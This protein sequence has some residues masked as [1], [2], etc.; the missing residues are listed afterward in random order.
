[1]GGPLFIILTHS[2]ARVRVR[3]QVG[4]QM[5]IIKINY[6]NSNRLSA[7]ISAVTIPMVMMAVP[8]ETI[9]MHLS[10]PDGTYVEAYLMGDEH[11]HYVVSS[12]HN[13]LLE[14]NPEGF[15]ITAVR[16]GRE[17]Y[18]TAGDVAILQGD[19][20]ST[21]TLRHISAPKQMGRL[22]VE[23]RT[24]YPT[25]GEGEVHSLVVLIEYADTKFTIPDVQ[26]AISRLCNEEGYSDY[27]AK[28]SARDYYRV[29]SGGKFNPVFD[30]T[31]PITLSE[32]SKY[33]VGYGTGSICDRFGDAIRQ[34][35][36]ELHESG[37]VDFSKYDYDGDGVVDNV[38]FFFAGYG[39]A[40]TGRTDCIWP[41]QAD[42]QMFMD[43][44]DMPELV[45]DGKRIA[46]YACSAELKGSVPQINQ[47]YLCG[48]GTFCHE[49]GHVLG[50]PDLYDTV[51]GNTES[52]GYW[53]IMAYGSYN[54]K[55]TCPPMMSAYERWLCR[56]LELDEAEPGTTYCLSPATSDGYNGMRI[57]I[58]T[59]GKAREFYIIESRADESWDKPLADH[60]L[61]IWH[62][63]Y[64]E[65]AW[66]HNTVNCFGYPRVRLH[67]A[68]IE[69]D[70]TTWPGKNSEY[71]MTYPDLPNGLLPSGDVPDDFH[72]FLTDI[73]FDCKN[74]IG[75]VTYNKI[76][77]Y[78]TDVVTLNSNPEFEA[79]KR[80]V[81]LSWNP[82]SECEP[83]DEY[84]LTV[85][86][87]GTDGKEYV[88]DNMDEKNVNNVTE[89]TIGNIS[90]SAWKQEFNAYV[91]VV[92]Y[93]IPAKTI[94]NVIAF[95]PST[96]CSTQI[97]SINDD[98]YG[99]YVSGKCILA[100]EGANIYSSN[101]IRVKN[102]H[103]LAPG[104][105]IIEYDNIVTKVIVK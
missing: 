1:M 65:H 10:N 8:A 16:D 41:H 31:R 94:S 71:E 52:P 85:K 35:L 49:Y 99:I 50:L 5:K 54:D 95:N 97:N 72:I 74:G 69:K 44:Y 40:D 19:V 9:L 58:P 39:Q 75:Q 23:G 96:G 59:F 25:V 42:Y 32:T 24:T 57:S 88:V 82:S 22:D 60:G 29:A 20:L 38:Y 103:N 37:E 70:Q 104:L 30:V 102:P 101:G 80:R 91:R 48:I 13:R 4:G 78:P 51:G 7:V 64:D 28:G 79:E 17:L 27:G 26:Q 43:A 62:I 2:A 83:D 46:S 100:P 84:L 93:G 105:Y 47:P 67:K 77:D 56:W 3:I 90:P 68:S 34:S 87:I 45:F 76:T 61:V 98:N 53:D 6:M 73:K 89:I 14:K 21:S 81:K 36:T 92:R 86:R 15:W 18:A 63:D 55:S 66:I 33:Y 11:L 12:D